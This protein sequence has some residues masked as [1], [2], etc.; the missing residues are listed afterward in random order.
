MPAKEESIEKEQYISGM[1]G[2]GNENH[3]KEESRKRE[4]QKWIDEK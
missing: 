1:I 3:G 2:L 4:W